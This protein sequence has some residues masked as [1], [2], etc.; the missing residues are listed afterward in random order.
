MFEPK[1][2]HE[3]AEILD[4]LPQNHVLYRD[5]RRWLFCDDNDNI[6]FEQNPNEDTI[7]FL[8]RIKIPCSYCGEYREICADC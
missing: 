8:L 6:L 5:S 7:S 4:N 1:T 2:A 3:L